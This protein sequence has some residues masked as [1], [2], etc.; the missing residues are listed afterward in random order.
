MRPDRTNPAARIVLPEQMNRIGDGLSE[1]GERHALF[2]LFVRSNVNHPIP[3]DV[4]R[5][6]SHK[7]LATHTLP[8]LRESLSRIGK[9]TWVNP[10]VQTRKFLRFGSNS[11]ITKAVAA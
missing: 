5:H 8:P 9:L 1:D 7:E 3:D 11:L 6:F 10:C 4:L 2:G